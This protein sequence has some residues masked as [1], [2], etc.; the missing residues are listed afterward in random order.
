MLSRSV[1]SLIAGIIHG[2]VPMWLPAKRG[3][4]MS[5]T[6]TGVFARRLA[7]WI[8]VDMSWELNGGRGPLWLCA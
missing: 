7:V 5:G 1:T 6:G 4:G 8:Y 2:A 3:E